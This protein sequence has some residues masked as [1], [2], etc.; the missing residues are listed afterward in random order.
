[1]IKNGGPQIT[2]LTSGCEPLALPPSGK[3]FTPCYPG[4]PNASS[5]LKLGMQAKQKVLGSAAVLVKCG[6]AKVRAEDGQ[7]GPPNAP[8]ALKLGMLAKQNILSGDLSLGCWAVQCAVLS[9][10]SFKFDSQ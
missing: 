1:M 9:G 7:H 6:R 5:A 4:L 3:F 10:A 2:L 8:S